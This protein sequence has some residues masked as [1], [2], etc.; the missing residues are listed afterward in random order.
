MSLIFALLSGNRWS[1]SVF[2]VTICTLL[3]AGLG[4]VVFSVIKA[5]VP[6]FFEILGGLAEFSTSQRAPSDFDETSFNDY[7]DG[8]EEPRQVP[9]DD[10]SEPAMVSPVASGSS[11]HFGDHILVDKVKIKNE[12]K[13]MAEAIRT[14]LAKED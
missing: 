10:E 6:E 5:K 1:H 12:P 2:V 9:L 4:F 11:Q 3:S 8:N 7:S 13:L 14:L